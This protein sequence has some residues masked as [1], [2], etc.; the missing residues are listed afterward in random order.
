MSHADKEKENKGYPF[1]HHIYI[2]I[3]IYIYMYIYLVDGVAAILFFLTIDT[4]TAVAL[5]ELGIQS[6][7]PAVANPGNY[8]CNFMPTI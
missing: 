7:A 3:Y 4:V 8:I 2:Y 6:F 5:S 1:E